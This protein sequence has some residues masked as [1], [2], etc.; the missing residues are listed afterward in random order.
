MADRM[1]ML[2]QSQFDEVLTPKGH[3]LQFIGKS[4][5]QKKLF[6]FRNDL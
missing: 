2:I 4:S 1:K 5:S 6:L 3:T